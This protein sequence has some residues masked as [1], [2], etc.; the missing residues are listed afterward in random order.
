MCVCCVCVVY[1]VYVCMCAYVCVCVC[2][3]VCVCCV[4]FRRV[5]ALKKKKKEFSFF[6]RHSSTLETW[7]KYLQL[8]SF[9]VSPSANKLYYRGEQTFL[10]TGQIWLLFFISGLL[11]LKLLYLRKK[12][13]F[14]ANF[15]LFCHLRCSCRCYINCFS[16]VTK[17]PRTTKKL[18]SRSMGR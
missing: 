12:N 5:T 14:L 18:V 16:S 6:A 3:C 13:S 11:L 10:I 17:S 2:I 8:G 1:V 15:C 4:C 9:F 7:S